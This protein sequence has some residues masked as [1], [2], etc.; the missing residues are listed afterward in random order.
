[1]AT[2]PTQF[3]KESERVEVKFLVFRTL[4][5]AC[6]LGIDGQDQ[7][8][9]RLDREQ[10][11]V[12]INSVPIPLDQGEMKAK[13]RLRSIAVGDGFREKVQSLKLIKSLL[14]I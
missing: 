5:P 8:K 1:M 10:N 12:W 2:I 6:I 13:V 3:S 7:L 11:F 14:T 4:V 9:I